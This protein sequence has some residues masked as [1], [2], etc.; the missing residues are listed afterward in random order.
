MLQKPLVGQVILIVEAS[1]SHSDTPHS[2]ELRWMSDQPDVE[3]SPENTRHSQ[4]TD[5]HSRGRIRTRISSKSEVA[6]LRLG[7]ASLGF[8]PRCE[9]ED[10]S[11][12]DL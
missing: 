12:V 7:R 8:G 1:P 6:N 11:K 3:T 4:Q 2:V 5:F 9:W 10:N